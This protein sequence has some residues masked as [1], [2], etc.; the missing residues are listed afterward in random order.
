MHKTAHD[1]KTLPRRYADLVEI[2][3]PRPIHVESEYEEAVEMIHVMAGHKLAR[4]Q[5]DYL[6]ALSTFVE[7]YEDIHYPIEKRS[8]AQILAHLMEQQ[9]MSANDLGRLLG[10]KSL[11]SRILRGER[12]LSKAHIR[13]LRDRFGFSADLF[14]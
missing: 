9:G 10:D 7:A 5:E 13:K 6:D 8:P 2:L 11:G 14:L 12:E 1:I 4:D 3:P